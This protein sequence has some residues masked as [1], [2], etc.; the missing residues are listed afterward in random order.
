MPRL[1]PSQSLAVLDT[2][3]HA[4]R[5][6][7]EQAIL[8]RIYGIGDTSGVADQQYVAGFQDA[9]SAAVDYGIAAI[10][11]GQDWRSPPVPSQLLVQARLAARNGVSLDTVLRRYCGGNTHFSDVLIEEAAGARVSRS[12]LKRLLRAQATSFDRLIA[13][14][15]EEY[16]REAQAHPRTGEQRRALLVERLLA[17]ELLDV[18]ELAYDVD[19]WHLGFVAAG[20]EAS[21]AI[22]ELAATLDR[23]LL[24][25]DR[26]EDFAWG[27]LGGQRPYEPSERERLLTA[28]LPPQASVAIGEPAHG[29]SGWRLT[30][31]QAAAVLP[32]AV[33]G[34]EKVA[35]YAEAPLLASIMQ[36]DLLA[37]SLRRL[38]L[39]PLRKERDGG[40][41]AK[42]TLRAYFAAA[43]NA[44]SAAAALGVNR[45][46]V[47]SRL[48][49]IEDRFG[50]PLDSASA[51]IE[52]A[53]RLDELEHH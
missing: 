47:S 18:A 33:R 5:A 43:R 23:A 13:A 17:G 28:P 12:E 4:R 21:C 27:W 3:L 36:D 11:V 6:E 39:E 8:A 48:A 41:V 7:L 31:R 30:H 51:E 45:R 22:R 29:L 49:T 26:G 2:Q 40:G 53:L 34:E 35:Q 46:T 20:Q 10:Q 52:T 16:S 24:L 38:Y 42:S 19:S 1:A 50:R 32:I 14:V 37:T 9:V 44:S 15:S 25:V